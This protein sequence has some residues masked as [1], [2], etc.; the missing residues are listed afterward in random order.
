MKTEHNKQIEMT[1][2]TFIFIFLRL[3][4]FEN[5][6]QIQATQVKQ[7]TRSQTL[8]ELLG[9]MRSR[10]GLFDSVTYYAY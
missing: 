7:Q 1:N 3:K 4:K 6:Q 2:V 9:I 5:M 10:D 8:T